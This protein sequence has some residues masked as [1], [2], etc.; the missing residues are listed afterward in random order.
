MQAEILIYGAYGYTGR[1]I[2]QQAMKQ[3]VNV[4]LAGRNEESLRQVA[5]ETGFT[6]TVISLEEDK[7][8]ENLL[9]SYKVVIHCAGPFS[10][11]ALPM[12][13]A[14]I[15]SKTHYIDITGEVSVFENIYSFDSQAK[16]A[17]IALIPGAGFDVV[18]TDCLAA[19]MKE[20]MSDATHLEMA[21]VGE[22]TGMSRG[23][24]VTMAKNASQGGYIREKGKLKQV[25]LAYQIKEV[26]FPH[27]K[28]WCMTI[29]WGDLMTAYYQTEIPNIKVF[30]G[31]SKK[32]LKR[33]RRFRF[34]KFLLGIAW[35]QKSVRKK[36]ENSVT[37]PSQEHLEKGKTYIIAT[38]KNDKGDT[39]TSTLITPEAYQLTSLTAL[40]AGLKLITDNSN[41]IG[42]LTP[43]QAFGKDFILEFEKVEREDKA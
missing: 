18:P 35:I 15:S 1:L 17:K 32:M 33:I 41:N 26:D 29:P 21:F 38:V 19:H 36:I 23:T 28:Q 37:G 43:A 12:V 11:T 10:E 13:K 5:T 24:A 4:H 40:K 34:L 16:E 2:A 6:Y 30:S 27:R 42:Y 14:C 39:K 22:K 31:A 25:P 9:S 8:L 7:K 3:A 20:R